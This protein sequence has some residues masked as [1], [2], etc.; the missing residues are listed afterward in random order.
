MDGSDGTWGLLCSYFGLCALAAGSILHQNFNT[1]DT[2]APIAR[3]LTATLYGAGFML[4]G[5][6]SAV[7]FWQVLGFAVPTV[8]MF[9]R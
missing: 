3:T 8:P 7:V 2:K 1:L 4:V 6:P 5:I 9:F